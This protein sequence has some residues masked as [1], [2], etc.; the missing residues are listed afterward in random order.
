MEWIAAQAGVRGDDDRQAAPH[1]G[2]LLDR[3]GVGERVQ[4]GAALFL[5]KRD[6][7]EAHLAELGNDVTRKTT[8]CFE[9]VDLALDFAR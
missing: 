8:V 3:D 2:Q 9:L 4:T 1:P 6:A 7:Q 5:G